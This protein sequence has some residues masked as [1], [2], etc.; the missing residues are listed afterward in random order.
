MD[1]INN[2]WKPAS[3]TV[4]RQSVRTNN[5]VEGWHHRINR[6][7]QKPNFQMYILIVL[8]HKEARLLPTQLKMVTEGKPATL[9]KKENQGAAVGQVVKKRSSSINYWRSA[10]RFMA[11]SN[12]LTIHWLCICCVILSTYNTISWSEKWATWPD[13]FDSDQ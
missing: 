6:K 3:W 8:L 12:D 11:A 5:D 4:C 2:T 7:A 10:A 13:S 1:Y 9:P